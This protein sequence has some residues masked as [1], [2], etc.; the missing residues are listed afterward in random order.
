MKQ[1][2]KYFIV[3]V[4]IS[5]IGLTG[6]KKDKY[7]E[8]IIGKWKLESVIVS[9]SDLY[10]QLHTIN[11]SENNIIYEFKK[12]NKLVVTSS[13]SGNSQKKEYS[14]KCERNYDNFCTT[15]SV[16]LLI[17]I[18]KETYSGSLVRKIYDDSSI[19]F[20]EYGGIALL[21]SSKPKKIMDEVDLMLIQDSIS[22]WQKNFIK[23]K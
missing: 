16:G 8:D 13:I 10:L 3:L 20:D 18:D 6:C 17:K 21:N 23:L 7:K 12:N 22:F 1:I 4:L 11:Y 5:A 19:S 14:Y 15:Y 2:V 9:K